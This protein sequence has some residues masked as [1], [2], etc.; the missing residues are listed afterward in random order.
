MIG[1]G[2]AGLFLFAALATTLVVPAMAQP[3]PIGNRSFSPRVFQTQQ[4]HYL[5]FSFNF[6]SCV[7]VATTGTVCAAKVGTL[8]YNAFLKSVVMD[9]ITVF[10]PAGGSATIGL[11]TAATGAT[12]LAAQNVFTGAT[13]GTAGYVWCGTSCGAGTFA[14]IGLGV[15]GAGIA[16]TGTLGG[17]DVYAVF[18]VTANAAPQGTTGAAVFIIEYYGPNDGN[19][20]MVPLGATAVAC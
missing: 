7:I 5:R 2:A 1:A 19:C 18:T 12:I 3:N 15:T 20:T 10:N 13:L 4:T 16:Q 8:P 6:N 14:G 17:F 9:L 11:S